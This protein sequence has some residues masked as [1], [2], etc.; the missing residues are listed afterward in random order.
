MELRRIQ[1]FVAVAE[2]A[3]YD[4]LPSLVR[5]LRADLPASSWTST[6]RC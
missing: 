6:A 5:V 3:H 4:L 1:Y 2:E